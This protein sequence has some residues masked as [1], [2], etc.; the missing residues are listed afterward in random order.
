DHLRREVQL[1]APSFRKGGTGPPPTSNPCGAGLRAFDLRLEAGLR[2]CGFIHCSNAAC[3]AD[4]ARS[5]CQRPLRRSGLRRDSPPSASNS[6]I[7]SR[8]HS[9]SPAVSRCVM[10]AVVI[11][12]RSALKSYL[13]TTTTNLP[14]LR[15]GNHRVK[16]RG[17]D[18]YCSGEACQD[19]PL[20]VLVPASGR[21]ADPDAHIG[22]DPIALPS[23][24]LQP[25]VAD[26]VS[27]PA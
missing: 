7:Q 10:Y 25:Q 3:A 1:W 9:V 23:V 14:P 17:S 16:R 26:T 24:Q 22:C 11:Q 15:R 12:K 4:A 19:L 13:T 8:S 6:E 27:T 21:A 18:Q 5:A 2:A 20:S